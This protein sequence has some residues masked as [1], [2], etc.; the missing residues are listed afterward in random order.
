MRITSLKKGF[1]SLNH[2]NLVHKLTLISQAMKIPDAKAAVDTE[3]EKLEK[4]PAWQLNKVQSKKDVILEAQKE[5]T[6]VHFATLMEICHLKKT[7]I[8]NQS[9]NNTKDESFSEVTL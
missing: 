3:W 2:H 6:N 8:W 9:T 1:N 5:K 4:M 7:R